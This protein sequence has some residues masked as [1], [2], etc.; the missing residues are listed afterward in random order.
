MTPEGWSNFTI[1]NAVSLIIDHRGVTP[2]KLGSD[3]TDKGIPV[4]SAK[5]IVDGYVRPRD[6][7]R[8]VPE[9]LYPRWMSEPL[10]DG[11]VLVTS[12]APLGSIAKFDKQGKWCLGQRLF[13][14][15]AGEFVDSS[16]LLYVLRGPQVQ[17][18][19]RQ[20][21]SGTTAKGIKQTELVKIPLL[22]PPL[23]EQRKIAEILGSVDEAIQSTKKV[24]SRTKRVKQ[25]LLQELLTRGI[26][27]TRFKKTEIGE[28]PEEW[29]VVPLSELVHPERPITY[30]I[31]QTGPYIT[32]GIPCVRVVDIVKREIK[33]EDLI[34]T[35]EQISNQYRRTILEKDD[36]ILALRGEIGHV[37]QANQSLVGANLTRGVAL[38]APGGKVSSRYLLWAL[39]APIVTRQILV[40]VNGSALKEIPLKELRKVP[41][42]VPPK[43]EQS[44]I[45]EHLQDLETTLVN[46]GRLLDSHLIVKQGLMQDLLTGRVRVKV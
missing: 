15:R 26:G 7:F 41:V 36:I 1:G 33:I 12:E 42:P 14:L 27:H 37:I 43:A 32:N 6:G 29:E 30:G 10:I 21:G 11:D 13:A 38:V 35:T 34:T 45:S 4:L 28:I 20:R 18:E 2:R 16:F 44:Q 23:P 8:H 17:N 39:R 9:E 3:F 5:N 19:F 31:V 46:H 40:R 25:G 24:I 22:L